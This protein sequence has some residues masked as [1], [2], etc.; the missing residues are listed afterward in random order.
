MTK[1]KGKAKRIFNNMTMKRASE[2]NKRKKERIKL[3]NVREQSNIQVRKTARQR[4]KE[5]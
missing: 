3:Y 2:K 5:Y 4:C 1:S